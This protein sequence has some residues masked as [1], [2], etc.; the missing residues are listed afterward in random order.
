[1]VGASSDYHWPRLRPPPWHPFET[2]K[3]PEIMFRALL[4]ENGVERVELARA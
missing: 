3:I 2:A 4:T 1:L